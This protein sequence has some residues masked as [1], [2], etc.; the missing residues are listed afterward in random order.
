[1]D[2][3]G[4]VGPGSCIGEPACWGA[5]AAV[6]EGSCFGSN[7]CRQATGAVV[8]GASC[9]EDTIGG[10]GGSLLSSDEQQ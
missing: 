6:G 2:A 8:G 9:G 10:D 4:P 3:T 5:T 7:A 1:M